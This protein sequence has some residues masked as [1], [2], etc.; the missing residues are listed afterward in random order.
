MAWCQFSIH[1][2]LALCWVKIKQLILVGQIVI[3]SREPCFSIKPKSLIQ[4]YSFQTERI[5]E[6]ITIIIII[7]TI[8]ILINICKHSIYDQC[9]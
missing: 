1:S 8:I 7:K 5:P 2:G 4:K 3:T 9:L 6:I